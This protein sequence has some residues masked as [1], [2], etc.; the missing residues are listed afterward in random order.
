MNA[1]RVYVNPLLAYIKEGVNVQNKGI[2][3][4]KQ[5]NTQKHFKVIV[6]TMPTAI[7]KLDP[8]ENMV[9]LTMCRKNRVS[10]TLGQCSEAVIPSLCEPEK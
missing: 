7:L 3:N 9:S 6:L 2:S 1:L 8:L 10:N 4:K 5:Q